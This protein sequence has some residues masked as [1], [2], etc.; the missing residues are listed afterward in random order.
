MLTRAGIVRVIVAVAVLVVTWVLLGNGIG[1]RPGTG[2]IALGKIERLK[3]TH[4]A[5]PAS[6]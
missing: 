4:H 2:T 5:C 1:P 6:H 3:F